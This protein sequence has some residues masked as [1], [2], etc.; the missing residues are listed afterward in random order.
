ME[1]NI[2]IEVVTSGECVTRNGVSKIGR[3]RVSV[4][5]D[6]VQ[7]SFVSGK[8]SRSLHS[9]FKIPVS[10]MDE[11]FDKW[12]K[13]RQVAAVEQGKK[14]SGK[15]EAPDQ[16]PGKVMLA[17]NDATAAISL[18]RQLFEAQ[19]GFCSKGDKNG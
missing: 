1:D 5:G 19:N 15:K 6:V 18:A 2:D 9:G 16:N 17:L 12:S 13:L 7:F 11:L 8:L 14:T 4:N 10:A 3:M